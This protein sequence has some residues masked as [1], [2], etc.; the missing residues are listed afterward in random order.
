MELAWR[1]VHFAG[2]YL[3]PGPR[4]PIDLDTILAGVII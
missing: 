2:R 1:H 3:F 4:Q